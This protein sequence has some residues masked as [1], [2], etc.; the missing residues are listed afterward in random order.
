MVTIL[1]GGTV[2]PRLPAVRSILHGFAQRTGLEGEGAPQH[3]YL[4]TDAFAVCTF[5]AL[6]RATG[7]AGELESALRL[8]D[9]V[10]GTLG[11][12]RPDDVR[13][14]WISG[15]GEVEGPAHPTRGG[16]RIGKPLPERS[17]LAPFDER[18]EWERDGQYFHY[19][20]KWM[21]A[22]RCAARDADDPRYLAWA[23]ELARAAHTGFVTR[24]SRD[25]PLR[26]VWKASIDLSRPLVPVQG[27]QDPLD[28][29]LTLRELRD[30]ALARGWR[31][32]EVALDG[33]I[34]DLRAL[35]QP[36]AWGTIDPLGVGGLLHDAYRLAQLDDDGQGDLAW[37]PLL[38]ELGSAGVT[39]I[40]Q[41]G[42]LRR[43]AEERLAFR[44]LGLSIGL[45]AARR[46]AQRVERGT[47]PEAVTGPLERALALL[48]PFVP[49]AES[50]EAFWSQPQN[51]E[52]TTWREHLDID[53]VMLATSRLP[54][55]FL[56]P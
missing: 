43:P 19:L 1:E 25:G 39:A 51:Q 11:R 4:W 21:H 37:L 47:L 33:A 52:A 20:T 23:I 44:E 49:L 38:V 41:A 50:I 35:C 40:A 53:A 56:E 31:Q 42:L 10:H 27:A 29:L 3:R 14:G 32:E 54:A 9:A 18:R 15:L 7:E 5:L 26:M 6:Y 34:A 24:P 30:A 48:R 8:I 46:L 22:L 16:L 17:P 28:G 45:H 2:Q 13:H 36:A 12:H 55:G